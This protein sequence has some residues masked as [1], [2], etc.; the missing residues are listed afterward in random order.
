[1]ATGR[2]CIDRRS[3]L[4]ACG[5]GMA[6]WLLAANAQS[7]DFDPWAGIDRN[8][9]IPSVEK[10][11]NLQ[12]PERWR[13]IPEGRIMPGNPFQR[14]LVSSF[15]A[16][17]IFR[18][19]DVGFGGGIAITDIDFREQR[20]REF[21]ALFLSY[22]VEGQQSYVGVWRRWLHQLDAPE[23]GIFQEE[24]SFLTGALGYQKALT[25]RFYGFGGDSSENGESS[26]ADAA[27]F[28]HFGID[29]ALR[30]PGDD[31]VGA[32][33]IRGEWHRLSEGKVSGEPD[34]EDAFRATFKDAENQWLLWLQTQLRYDTRDSQVLPYR[35][36]EVGAAIDSALLQSGQDVGAILSAF[37]SKIFPVP[38]LLH[39]GGDPEEEHPPTDTLAFSLVTRGTAGDLPFF[40]LPTLGGSHTLRGYIE[41]RFRDRATWH[42][43]AEYRFW[44]IPRGFPIPFTDALRVERV[45]LALFAESGSLDEDWWGLFDS[46]VRFSGGIGLRA[47]L[48]RSA[49]F[50]VDIGFSK[51]G[52]EVSAGFGL[53]F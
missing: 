23:G 47:T 27:I 17:I 52:V 48:E 8:G 22:S 20:R 39:D 36:F 25:R 46:R 26:Y 31:W 34:T 4:R 41:G 18:D 24:R 30:H 21:G 3:K 6:L 2:N 5:L 9:R 13:Y 12:H 45:G 50:R 28:G 43:A 49:P 15:I 7:A 29:R 14:F 11:A 16:P 51:E 32:I 37:G 10:P 53:T 40:S 33:G 19:T 44:V 1:M 38:P 42:A 35:G